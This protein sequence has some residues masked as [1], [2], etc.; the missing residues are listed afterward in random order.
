MHVSMLRGYSPASLITE[1]ATRGAADAMNKFQHVEVL[2]AVNCMEAHS[3]APEM[4]SKAFSKQ[5]IIPF[6]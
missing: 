3:T 5:K 2:S 6:I 4:I 1:Q